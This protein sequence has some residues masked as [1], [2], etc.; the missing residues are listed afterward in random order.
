[1][2]HICVVN[3]A[4]RRIRT[5]R[6][7]AES[8]YPR[9]ALFL[10]AR[11]TD[12]SPH[13]SAASAASALAA[14]DLFCRQLVF[15]SAALA[16]ADSPASFPVVSAASALTCPCRVFVDRLASAASALASVCSVSSHVSDVS[17]LVLDLDRAQPHARCS[18][19]V[20]SAYLSSAYL[21]RAVRFLIVSLSL[22][23]RITLASCSLPACDPRHLR[24]RKL[25]LRSL[26]SRYLLSALCRRIGSRL[27]SSRVCPCVRS[28]SDAVQD[29]LRADTLY[30]RLGDAAPRLSI[31]IGDGSVDRNLTFNLQDRSTWYHSVQPSA[32][33]MSGVTRTSL[34]V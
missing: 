10:L 19:C 24:R 22:P 14:F 8:G 20:S 13:P 4:Q 2:S 3:A 25:R 34:L 30:P 1:M 29:M 9:L 6:L 15:A 16:L 32:C 33:Y 27:Q 5:G 28:A 21:S 7:A 17:R 26:L 18:V 31:C 23:A 11:S 12:V